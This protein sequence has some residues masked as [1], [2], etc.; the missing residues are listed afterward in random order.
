MLQHSWFSRLAASLLVLSLA[1]AC[2]QPAPDPPASP[3]YLPT[4][5]IKDLMQSVVDTNADVVWLSVSTVASEKGLVE[6][7]PKTDEEWATVRHGAIALAEAANLLMM[8]GRHVARPGEKSETPG[9]ELEPEEMEALI[10]KDRDTWYK[11]AAALHDAAL[12]ALK[13]IE[14]KD[15]DKVFQ[16]GSQI[17]EACENCHSHY[18]YP[19]EKIPPPTFNLK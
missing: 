12:V 18:W 10:N 11:R 7:A 17:E 4:A 9:V 15:A 5:T 1:T 19:N 13:A 6:T 16:V 14:A 3:P 8:P 2:R